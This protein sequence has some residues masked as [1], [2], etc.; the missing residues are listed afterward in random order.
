MHKWLPNL[1]AKFWLP[2]L[3]LYQTAQSWNIPSSASKELKH[4]P[5]IS[6]L[7]SAVF[8]Y[9]SRV[10]QVLMG[11][12][13]VKISASKHCLSNVQCHLVD[14][15]R[16]CYGIDIQ[17]IEPVVQKGI[18]VF[19]V[20]WTKLVSEKIKTFQMKPDKVFVVL[21]TKLI[22]K[23]SSKRFKVLRI[24]TFWFLMHWR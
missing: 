2:N 16:L 5:G 6:K 8:I 18:R 11:D 7:S 12:G 9:I 3:V 17:Q 15:D 1:V 21:W 24:F 22:F 19:V 4:W 14:T 10:G 20:L 23:K 13:H